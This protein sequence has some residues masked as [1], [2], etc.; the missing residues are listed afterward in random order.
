MARKHGNYGIGKARQGKTEIASYSKKGNFGDAGAKR[1]G[2][3]AYM[4]GRGQQ[5]SGQ[6]PDYEGGTCSMDSGLT[7]S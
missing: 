7:P 6:N 3:P 1:K 5:Q 4:D 2:N